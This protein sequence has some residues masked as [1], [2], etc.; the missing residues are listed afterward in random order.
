MLQALNL[1]D[2]PAELIAKLKAD[3]AAK[4]IT[5]RDHCVT[6][7]TGQTLANYQ[8]NAFPAR[9]GSLRAEVDKRLARPD[10]HPTCQC[11]VCLKGK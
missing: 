11:A 4:G 3:A 1:R 9:P 5:L 7:L 10:H 8:A 2:V 6:L